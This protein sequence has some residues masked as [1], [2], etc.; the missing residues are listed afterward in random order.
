MKKSRK[1]VLAEGVNDSQ[2]FCCG[3]NKNRREY[4]PRNSHQPVR[5][6]NEHFERH[7]FPRSHVAGGE[8]YVPLCGMCHDT[9]DRYCLEDWPEYLLNEISNDKLIHNLPI[10]ELMCGFVAMLKQEEDDIYDAAID[11]IFNFTEEQAWEIIETCDG[12]A[13]RLL[14]LKV[15]SMSFNEQELTV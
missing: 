9:V 13:M 12:S 5:K 7:H 10:L 11:N 3:K 14:A 4:I 6:Q 2:C 1:Y 15:I 8:T